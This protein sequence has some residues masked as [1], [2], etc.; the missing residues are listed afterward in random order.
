MQFFSPKMNVTPAIDPAHPDS[1]VLDDVTLVE[2]LVGSN[3][4]QLQQLIVTESYA[5]GYTECH[6]L[7]Q[8]STNW[9]NDFETFILRQ[10]NDSVAL[11]PWLC[12]SLGPEVNPKMDSLCECC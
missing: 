1:L 3:Y 4:Q 10:E 2:I 5:Y 9:K 6:S 12:G 11:K 8:K 7:C